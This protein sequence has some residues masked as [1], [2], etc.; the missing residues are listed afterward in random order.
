MTIAFREASLN[1]T[2]TVTRNADN[3]VT[4]LQLEQLTTQPTIY[5][6]IHPGSLGFTISKAET[7]VVDNSGNR[8]SATTAQG[9]AYRIPSGYLC[10][11]FA[12]EAQTVLNV[13][14]VT[15]LTDQCGARNKRAVARN[16]GLTNLQETVQPNLQLPLISA[17]AR[18][19]LGDDFVQ[20][21]YGGEVVNC[22][23]LYMNVKL[24]GY[25]DNRRE[26]VLS[27]G[28]VPI[29]IQCNVVRGQ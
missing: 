28:R 7:E 8:Y 29:A 16:Y 20:R 10:Y 9:L 17:N 21:W 15:P 27:A 14:P 3:E 18:D 11:D 12:D 2:L 19:L 24:Y 22:P 5:A 4:G 1:S 13:Q 26:L 23:D 6:A 25:D